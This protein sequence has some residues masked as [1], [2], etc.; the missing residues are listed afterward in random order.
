[1]AKA[2]AT[3]VAEEKPITLT[4]KELIDFLIVCLAAPMKGYPGQQ[5]GCLWGLPVLIEGEPGIAKTARINQVA[6]ALRA[7]LSTFFAAPHPPES[8]GGALIPDGKG[9]ATN[10]VALAEL[11]KVID[12]GTG[13]LFFDEINGAAPATQGALQSLVHERQTAGVSI[14]GSV[15]IV[16]AQN[17]EEIATGGYR[18]SPPVAN[19]FVHI[20]DA[21]PTASEW[22]AWLVGG[23]QVSSSLT[24]DDLEEKMAKC[25]PDVYPS[26]QGLFSGFMSSRPDLIHKRPKTRDPRAGKAWPSHRTWDYATRAWCTQLIMEQSD[27]VAHAIVEACVGTGA[28]KEFLAYVKETD[29][30]SPKDVLSGKW[31]IDKDR[32]DVVLAA[33]SAATAYVCQRPDKAERLEIA[34]KL[35]EALERLFLAEVEDI[36][37]PLTEQLIQNQLGRN[38]GNSSITAASLKVYLRL[39]KSGLVAEVSAAT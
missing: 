10:I 9:G 3:V 1:M 37:V 33:Y 25:W 39:N 13:I 35:W 6:K 12:R 27:T 20:A 32:V 31:K 21:G 19:R 30:P 22:C 29:L 11:R 2:P 7:P 17:P 36:A 8:F 14:P 26:V 16:S 18:L 5:E 34:P 4:S 24:L 23:S 38:S 28:A 15:R